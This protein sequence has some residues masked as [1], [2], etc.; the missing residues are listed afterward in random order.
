M[1]GSDKTVATIVPGTGE[2]GDLTAGRQSCGDSLSDGA[3]GI[4]HQG[5]AG[6]TACYCQPIGFGHF[7]SGEDL[8]HFTG[9]ISERLIAQTRYN[10]LLARLTLTTF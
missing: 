3:A 9:T 5:Q 8:D 1:S 10:A 7:G 4:F 2:D 6:K